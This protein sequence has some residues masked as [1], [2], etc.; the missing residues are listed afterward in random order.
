MCANE[1]IY[2]PFHEQSRLYNKKDVTGVIYYSMKFVIVSTAGTHHHVTQKINEI[3]KEC[4][5]M[6]QIKYLNFCTNYEF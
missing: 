3:F 2:P 1:A 4:I 5:R 6:L